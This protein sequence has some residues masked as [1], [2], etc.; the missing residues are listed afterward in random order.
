[1][2]SKKQREKGHLF[3]CKTI[4]IK[5]HVNVCMVKKI[6]VF[7]KKMLYTQS[8]KCFTVYSINTVYSNTFRNVRHRNIAYANT[9]HNVRHRNIV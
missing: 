2:K 4:G 3:L 8:V 9:F 6:V 7:T 1:M 5:N